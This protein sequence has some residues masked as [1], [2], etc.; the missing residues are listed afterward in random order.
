M[1]WL[2]GINFTADV[3]DEMQMESIWLSGYKADNLCTEHNQRGVFLP[4][5]KSP[6]YSTTVPNSVND[7]QD[8]ISIKYEAFMPYKLHPSPHHLLKI[9]I[10]IIIIIMIMKW[11]MMLTLLGGTDQVYFST[12]DQP[13]H[14]ELFLRANSSKYG[15]VISFVF[16]TSHTPL[17]S[18]LI[19]HP[20]IYCLGR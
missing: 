12:T 15:F 16:I 18:L 14:H 13:E 8:F 11:T 6:K 5:T 1:T 7:T 20:I 17:S 10:I 9:Y 4:K 2:I 3:W 19:L